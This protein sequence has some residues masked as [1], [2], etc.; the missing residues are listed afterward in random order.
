MNWLKR[1]SSTKSS[2]CI[3]C[4]SNI[5]H[6]G[7]TQADAVQTLSWRGRPNDTEL[8]HALMHGIGGTCPQCGRICCAKCY[9]D[10]QF[11]CPNCTSK[12]PELGGR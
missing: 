9:Y 6:F 3:S 2:K 7:F 5:D 12:I 4:S 10:Q 8:R 1:L 11:A